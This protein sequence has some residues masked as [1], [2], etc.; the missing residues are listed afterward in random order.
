MFM[1]YPVMVRTNTVIFRINLGIVG[2]NSIIDKRHPVI[3]LPNQVLFRTNAV[4][5][6]TR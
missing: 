4:I 5:F 3:L 1:T 6:R 2:T